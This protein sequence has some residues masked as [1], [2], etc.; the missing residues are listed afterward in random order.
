MTH[1]EMDQVLMP[2]RELRHEATEVLTSMAAAALAPYQHQ[3]NAA[4]RR[5][6]DSDTFY[7]LD[8]AFGSV[9]A[10]ALEA[11]F[12]LGFQAASNPGPFLFQEKAPTC[13]ANTDEGFTEDPY[14]SELESILG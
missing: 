10:A 5:V 14:I 8:S 7:A 3:F 4:L 13:G 12:A 2:D 6:T 1:Q 11:A 9:T